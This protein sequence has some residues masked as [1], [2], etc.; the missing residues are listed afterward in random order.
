M[1]KKVDEQPVDYI[2]TDEEL[3]SLDEVE[4]CDACGGWVHPSTVSDIRKHK[5]AMLVPRSMRICK[6]CRVDAFKKSRR[7]GWIIG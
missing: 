6:S 1:P 2:P 7:D 3:Q 5:D 4:K